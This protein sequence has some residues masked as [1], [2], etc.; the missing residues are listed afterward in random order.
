M[1][2]RG[3]PVSAPIPS[4]SLPS[5]LH[6]Q[7]VEVRAGDIK[8]D[9]ESLKKVLEGVDILINAVEVGVQ[10]VIPCDFGTPGAKGIQIRDFVK[11]RD[12]IPQTFIDVSWWSQLYLPLPIRSRAPQ[13]IGKYVARIITDPRTL[14]HAVI[15]WEDEVSLEE[16]HEIGE[17]V[18]GEGDVRARRSSTQ[19]S[20]QVLG[21]N[22]LDNAKRPYYVNVKGL[23]PD[24]TPLPLELLAKE[25]YSMEVP[26]IVYGDCVAN[27]SY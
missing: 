17:R 16:A 10:R 4:R 24:I 6:A 19:V 26:G 3:G 9:S 5:E 23:Y 8:D 13:L 18:S 12:G 21:K 20:M 15:L 25:F 27:L 2:A 14:N 7:G 11:E 1:A 22:T